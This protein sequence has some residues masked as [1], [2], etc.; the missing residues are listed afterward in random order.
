MNEI[1]E[2]SFQIISCAGDAKCY[3]YEALAATKLNDTELYKEKMQ[4]AEEVINEAH[5]LQYQLLS[6]EANN[7][8]NDAISILVIHAQDHLM[9]TMAV[10]DMIKEVGDLYLL[11]HNR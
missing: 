5:K 3:A 2:V 1:Q 7:K 9:T 8:L 11:I 6:A 10:I 4:K